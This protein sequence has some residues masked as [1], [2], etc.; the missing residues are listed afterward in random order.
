MT[1]NSPVSKYVSR[2]QAE[3]GKILNFL[4]KF[5]FYGE[6]LKNH[7]YYEADRIVR[8]ELS[9]KLDSL[10]EPLRRIEENFVRERRMD[11]IGSTEVLLSVLER[12]KNEISGASYGLNG[13]GTGFKATESELEALAEWD[14]SLNQHAE[15]LSSKGQFPSFP[16]EVSV[17]LVRDWVSK[18]RGE[19]DEFDSALKKRKD[20]FLKQ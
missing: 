1:S 2:F 19:L 7:Q 3:K 18:Y 20:V 5:P 13:L 4:S 9:K 10:K 8:N 12:L 14:Y 11:L 16:P 15:E 6:V 17:D